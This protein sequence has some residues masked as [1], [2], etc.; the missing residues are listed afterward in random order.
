[1]A[2]MPA[3]IQVLQALLTPVIGVT[4][5]GIAYM[6]WTTAHNRLILDLFE[7]RMAVYQDVDALLRHVMQK[8][9]KV[10]MK[11]MSEFHSVRHQAKLLYGPEISDWLK[12]WHETLIDMGSSA[13]DFPG[14]EGE[15]LRRHRAVA[16]EKYIEAI[17]MAN[18][19]PE[20]FEPY[21][22]MRQRRAR[23]FREWFTDRNRIRRSY[24]DN[25]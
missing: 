8:G 25:A 5:A 10:E 18:K 14:R 9:P 3:W 17:E 12:A 15:E 22:A 13:D 16:R 11:R 6:Q 2:T 19:L 4:V 23:T 24:G 20:L 1:M 7:K 21:V